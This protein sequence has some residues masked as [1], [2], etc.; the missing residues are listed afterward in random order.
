VQF[1]SFAQMKMFSLITVTPGV[2]VSN[3][4]SLLLPK[5]SRELI[6]S[7]PEIFGTDGGGCEE[8]TALYLPLVFVRVQ[9]L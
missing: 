7:S 5:P 8:E 4:P 3:F 6:V 1:I 9:L 2:H